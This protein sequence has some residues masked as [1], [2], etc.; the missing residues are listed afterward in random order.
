ME[1][2]TLKNGNPI[3][4]LTVEEQRQGGIASGIT[5]AKRKT[6][7]EE[8]LNLLSDKDVNKN[9]S[10]S[11]LSKALDGDIRAFEVIRDTV[12]EKPIDK[13]DMNANVSYESKIR[14]VVDTDEY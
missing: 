7:K 3:H 1:K 14:E 5:R 12:G 10:L 2:K 8:L 4:T 6:F 9:I 13:V 11:L